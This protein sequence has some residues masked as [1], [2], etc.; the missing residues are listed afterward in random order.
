M[1]YLGDIYRVIHQVVRPAKNINSANEA[2]LD[3]SLMSSCHTARIHI[4][5]WGDSSQFGQIQLLV[6]TSGL[7]CTNED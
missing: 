5:C 2:Q 7:F 1:G 3:L 4:Q 6:K